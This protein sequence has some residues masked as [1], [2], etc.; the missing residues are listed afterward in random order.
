MLMK[1]YIYKLIKQINKHNSYRN[2]CINLIA[3]ENLM[4]PMARLS[5]SSDLG[6]RYT[7]GQPNNRWYAGCHYYDKIENTAINLAQ[8]LFHAKYVNLQPISGMVAN[9]VSYYSLLKP[10][11]LLLTL[12]VKH[13]GHYSHAKNNMLSLFRI[14]VG[15]LPFDEKEYSIDLEKAKKMIFK[16]KPNAILLGTSEFLFPAPIKELKRICDKTGTKIMYDAAH[17][18]GLIAGQT[19][20]DPLTEGA[21]MLSMSTNKTLSAPDHGIV[22]CNDAGLYRKNIE[23]GIVPMFTSNHHAHHV[24]GLAITLA[25]FEQFGQEY[26]FQVIKNAQTLAKALYEQGIMVLCPHKN[27]TQSHTVLFDGVI[28]G[29][30]AMKILE[31]VNIIVN[32][33]QL[34]W[35]RVTSPTGIRIGTN[36]ITRL[37]MKDNEMKITAKFISDSLLNRKPINFIRK[38]VIEFRK[39][40]R[41]I[42]YCFND[43][44][45]KN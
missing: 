16:K 45:M 36:E 26:A 14:R 30:K 37:G 31:K 42:Q 19:F 3:S 23:H 6:N 15:S 27:F 44:L 29:N 12:R 13:S 25:E 35:N 21:D 2:S 10:G 28:S 41:K 9:M 32:P 38:E 40:F 11:D 33:F 24:A 34:P 43:N 22:A 4:S 17:V 39:S 5:L 20:Q 7:V 18:S 8:K 1:N